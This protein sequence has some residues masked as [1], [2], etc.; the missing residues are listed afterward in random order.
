M[1]ISKKIALGPKIRP[2]IPYP[3]VRW[4]SP[5]GHSK[6]VFFPPFCQRGGNAHIVDY[7]LCLFFRTK[8]SSV[9]TLPSPI[10]KIRPQIVQ[11]SKPSPSLFRGISFAHS[12]PPSTLPLQ[13][14]NTTINRSS[15]TVEIC[16]FTVHRN[17]PFSAPQP[18]PPRFGHIFRHHPLCSVP[19]LSKHASPPHLTPRTLRLEA[20]I[21]T[22][23]PLL[24]KTLLHQGGSFVGRGGKGFGEGDP[25]VLGVGEE[26]VVVLSLQG[27]GAAEG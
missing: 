12:P 24:F 23:Q 7:V 16:F 1:N 2:R 18:H 4:K 10:S 15:N 25:G 17:T 14:T 19:S 6:G 20:P 13:E 27:V 11:K 22:H 21:C 9:K 26:G 8:M 3:T 5:W